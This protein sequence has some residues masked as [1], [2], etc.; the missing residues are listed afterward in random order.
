MAPEMVSRDPKL[1]PQTHG[2][3]QRGIPNVTLTDTSKNCRGDWGHQLRGGERRGSIRIIFQNMRGMGNASD[4]S[5][6]HKIDT[7]KKN[8][9]N[10]GI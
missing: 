9:I 6:Q 4:Q 10:E 7:L 1:Y 8:M 2:Q 5:S 3:H